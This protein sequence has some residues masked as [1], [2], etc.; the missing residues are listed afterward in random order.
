V[1]A[2][3]ASLRGIPLDHGSDCA[4]RTQEICTM[5]AADMRHSLSWNKPLRR[6]DVHV[7]L[8]QGALARMRLCEADSSRY[9]WWRIASTR[10]T[11]E[12]RSHASPGIGD[13]PCHTLHRVIASIASLMARERCVTGR[14][15]RA[16]EVCDGLRV[17]TSRLR[18]GLGC[19]CVSPPPRDARQ[20]PGI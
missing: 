19:R 9:L 16:L 13:L 5:T 17:E 20:P 14:Q 15:T 4:T 11:R 12:P 8:R 10:P 18:Q 7:E 2:S 6:R 3:T 1:L